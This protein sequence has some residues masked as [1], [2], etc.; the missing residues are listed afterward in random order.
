[1]EFHS[2]FKGLRASY[3]PTAR[4]YSGVVATFQPLDRRVLQ[5]FCGWWNSSIAVTRSLEPRQLRQVALRAADGCIWVGESTEC[6]SP[7]L[8]I[9]EWE[10]YQNKSQTT[11]FLGQDPVRRNIVVDKK[12]LQVQN[13][14]IS[15]MKF[16]IKIYRILKKLAKFAQILGIRNNT[17]KPALVQKFSRIKACT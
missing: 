14:N 2:G 17:F 10:Y 3:Q 9:L 12:C 7:S 13:F 4:Q 6:N 1:M 5:H 16:P 15:V 11:A 8:A